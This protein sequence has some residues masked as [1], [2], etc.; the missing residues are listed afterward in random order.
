MCIQKVRNDDNPM[1]FPVF[2]SASVLTFAPDAQGILPEKILSYYRILF[3]FGFM[4]LRLFYDCCDVMLIQTFFWTSLRPLR[5]YLTY[6]SS[7][8]VVF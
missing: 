6:F 8:S 5:F 4:G 7:L 3:A 1:V 2:R